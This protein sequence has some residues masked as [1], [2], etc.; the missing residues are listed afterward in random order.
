MNPQVRTGLLHG[1][2]F[3]GGFLAAIAFMASH[4]VDLYAA[5][6]QLNVVIKDFQVLLGILGPLASGLYGIW[7]ATTANKLIDISADPAV[8]GVITT[9]ALAVAV[10]SDKVQATVG[11]LPPAAQV[12]K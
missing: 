5:Y 3:S 2:T 1:A 12:T 11:A 4:K 9:Q 6:D 8:K 10:P 7:K